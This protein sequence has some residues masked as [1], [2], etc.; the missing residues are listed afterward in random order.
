MTSILLTRAKGM[1]DDLARLIIQIPDAEL[2][3]CNLIDYYK[4]PILLEASKYYDHIMRYEFLVITSHFCAQNIFPIDAAP[5]VLNT[6]KALV[7]G[8]KS[9]QIITNKGYNVIFVAENAE[10]LYQQMIKMDA[11]SALY[12]AGDNITQ[13]LPPFV[14]QVTAYEVRYLE[15]LSGAQMARYSLGIDYAA[16]YS[17]KSMQVFL[18]LM[19][20]HD[21][22]KKLQKSCELI[23]I[24]AKLA[25][26]ARP[27]F[28]HITA[29]QS[30]QL[31]QQQILAKL[32]RRCS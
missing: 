12:L 21:L 14:T 20:Q 8:T 32:Q 6:P 7:V 29:C 25:S 3:E 26:M 22:L 28:N 16:I 9:A 24:S 11:R 5:G 1:N 15:A 31:M 18:R 27:Y 4:M 2:L 19:Q 30:P 17:A 23:V 10:Q 13:E